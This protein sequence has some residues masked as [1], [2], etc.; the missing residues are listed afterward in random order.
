VDS[1]GTCRKIQNKLANQ[2][3]QPMNFKGLQIVLQG[4]VVEWCRDKRLITSHHT[5]RHCRIPLSLIKD[6]D[7]PDGMTWRCKSCRIKESI[8]KDSL[9]YASHMSIS[10]ILEL[11]YWFSI[12]LPVTQAAHECGINPNTAVEYY[13]IFRGICVEIS[14]GGEILGGEGK[15][16]EIDEMK[17]GKRKFHRGKRVDGQWCFGGIERREN[18]DDPIRCFIIPVED[19]S[20]TTLLPI[21]Q[22]NIKD[23]TTIY[24][25]CWKSYDCL[26][27]EG[28][29]HA[30]VN[31]FLHFKDPVT[32]VHINNVEGMWNQ[33]RR[34][35]PKFGTRKEHYSKHLAEFVVRN[36]YRGEN[37][38]ELLINRL[39]EFVSW[40]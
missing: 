2:I 39:H 26:K 32:N 18:K 7:S 20:K 6:T 28:Y 10:Q 24:S 9:F 40:D 23:G 33:V 27:D 3:F 34:S 13:K 8:R 5:C 25:D 11:L 1:C 14:L 22:N 4:D 16:V 30:S 12:K 31:H 29:I 17:L 19:R 15:I 35:L 21:I 37:F 36:R 38:F